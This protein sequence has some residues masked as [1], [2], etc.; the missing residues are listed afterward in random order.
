MS[1][2]DVLRYQ[3][4]YTSMVTY[5][6]GDVTNYSGVNYVS[7]GTGNTNNTPASSPAWWA[8]LA[9]VDTLAVGPSGPPSL[10]FVGAPV[11]LTSG[12]DTTLL[13][14]SIPQGVYAVRLQ[15][16]NITVRLGGVGSV[17]TIFP[18]HIVDPE[19]G[20]YEGFYAFGS[21]AGLNVISNQG[22]GTSYAAVLTCKPVI[23]P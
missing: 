10:V 14:A 22:P 9:P 17:S 18:L 1:I 3:E 7:L 13:T 21:S 12:T 6:V 15:V 19:H 20:I 8:S 23:I 5:T 11:T 2:L 16:G 4:E